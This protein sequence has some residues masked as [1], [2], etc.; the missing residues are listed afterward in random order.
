MSQ[1]WEYRAVRLSANQN[2]VNQTL[3]QWAAAGWELV[4]GTYGLDGGQTFASA[5]M[6]LF[7][8]RAK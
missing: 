6:W 1:E 4:N 2:D 8:R 5:S 7:W 3:A